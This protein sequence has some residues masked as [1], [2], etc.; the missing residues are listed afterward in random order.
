MLNSRWGTDAVQQN[1]FK[2]QAEFRRTMD[3]ILYWGG[4]RIIA[5]NYMGFKM[6]SD[7]N[8]LVDLSKMIVSRAIEPTFKTGG[9]IIPQMIG[10]NKRL[11][12][13]HIYFYAPILKEFNGKVAGLVDVI[14]MLLGNKECDLMAF[15]TGARGGAL[16]TIAIVAAHDVAEKAMVQRAFRWD[17][18]NSALSEVTIPAGD[19]EEIFSRTYDSNVWVADDIWKGKIKT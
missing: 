13:C 19:Y 12:E 14:T 17:A 11:K 2:R 10:V 6:S 7:C 3:K 4:Q 9:Y 15:V 8:N 18:E 5:D 1:F 16:G